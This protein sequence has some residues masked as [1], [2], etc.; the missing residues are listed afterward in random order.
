MADYTVQGNRLLPLHN[1]NPDAQTPHSS[2][3]SITMGIRIGNQKYAIGYIHK[4]TFDMSRDNK[5]IFQIEPY[6]DVRGDDTT[7]AGIASVYTARRFDEN[8]AYWPGEAIEV[9]PGKMQPLKLTLHRYALYTGNLMAA[10]TRASGSGVYDGLEIPPNLQ[11]SNAPIIRYVSLLQQVR[12]FDIYQIFV[13]PITGG[14]L[15]G[16]KFG[17][18]WFTKIGET[19]PDSEK[20]EPILEEGEIAATYVR[21]LSSSLGL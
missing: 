6:P 15:W 14:V 19:T 21:P 9:I 10:I 8:T 4:F 11:E 17:G 13:S 20:N 7:P 2:I 3:Q 5:T 16:R 18:C 12:P 1:M